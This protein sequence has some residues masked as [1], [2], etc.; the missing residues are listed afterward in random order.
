[1]KRSLTMLTC[2]A[3]AACSSGGDAMKDQIQAQATLASGADAPACKVYTQAEASAW[4]GAKV[5]PGE[6]ATGG[7]QWAVE[8][9]SGSMMLTIVPASYNERPTQQQGFRELPDIPAEAFVAPY[10]DGWL[11]GAVVGSDAVRVSL[12]GPAASEAKTVELLRDAIK[13]HH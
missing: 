4:V 2:L 1:M 9:G 10:F 11:A 12:D 3:V 7:C 5:Q 6:L 8:D 13:R